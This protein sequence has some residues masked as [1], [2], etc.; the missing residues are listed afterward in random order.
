MPEQDG[1]QTSLN[2]MMYF[3]ENGIDTKIIACSGYSDKK[4][5][6]HLHQIGV[7]ELILKPVQ[8]DVIKKIL[9]KLSN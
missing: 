6:E 8:M 2:L 1:I 9:I 7:S 5:V 3:E 4:I